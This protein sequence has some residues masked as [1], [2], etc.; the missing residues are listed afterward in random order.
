MKENFQDALQITLRWE[1]GLVD[2]PADPGGLTKWGVSLRFLR[3][4][5]VDLNGD[6]TV[7]GRDIRS[8]THEQRDAIYRDHFWDRCRCDELPIGIL[9]VQRLNVADQTQSLTS[10][11][12]VR[13][14]HPL[15]RMFG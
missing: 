1:G 12:V 6:G 10:H 8:L 5:G 14:E 4:I 13:F 7:D 2:H 15:P 9:P 11:A 3:A